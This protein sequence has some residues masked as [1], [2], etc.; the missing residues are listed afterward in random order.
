MGQVTRSTTI[1]ADP[2]TV[3]ATLADLGQAKEWMPGVEQ[4]D[5]VGDQPMGTGAQWIETRRTKRGLQVSRV[6]VTDFQ[7]EAALGLRATGKQLEM[8][9]RFN[10][11]P[12]AQGTEL[13]FQADVKGKGLAML[14][15]GR[16]AREVEAD[17]APML[18][19]LKQLIES[20]LVQ[21]ALDELLQA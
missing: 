9:C 14:F 18:D 10:L 19:R 3:F 15:P 17:T 1:Q 13:T 7:P 4:I 2:A 11:Q 21:A 6:Q 12:A 8:G 20:R 5:K 16:V